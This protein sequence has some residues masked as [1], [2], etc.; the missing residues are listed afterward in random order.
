[1]S[2]SDFKQKRTRESGAM[3]TIFVVIMSF[4]LIVMTGLVVD[5]GHV[6]SARREAKVVASAA[7]RGASQWFDETELDRGRVVFDIPQGRFTAQQLIR[8]AGYTPPADCCDYSTPGTV[9]VTVRSE[10]SMFLLGLIGISKVT[11]T[12]SAESTITPG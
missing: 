5:G 12:G 3:A 7:A 4:T 1:M 9:K 10:V 11:I 2:R 6:I 8:D